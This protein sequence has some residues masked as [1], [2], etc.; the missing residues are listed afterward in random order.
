LFRFSEF[1]SISLTDE[2]SGKRVGFSAVD[3]S[4]EFRASDNV[5]PLVGAAH[6]DAAVLVPI[7]PQKIV[8]LDELVTEFRKRHARL[9]SL[10]NGIL[11]HHV[12]D[13][14]VF[15]NVADE[16]QEAVL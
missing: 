15:A 10:L 2:G 8:S 1:R 12:V 5:S 7:E 13:G 6:L 4:D 16:I 11:R 9:E 14:D 3:L